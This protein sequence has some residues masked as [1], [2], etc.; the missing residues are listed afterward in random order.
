[1]KNSLD[2][3]SE[4]SEES[5][6][7]PGKREIPLAKTDLQDEATQRRSVT[8]LN[9]GRWW[10][11]LTGLI[12]VAPVT[13][14]IW[15][16]YRKWHAALGSDPSAAGFWRTAF[17]LNVGRFVVEIGLVA[18]IFFI[19]KPRPNMFGVRNDLESQRRAGEDKPDAP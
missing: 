10:I 5:L 2:R 14:T 8:W 18:L 16:N 6:F 13:S 1:L 3:H 19:L 7:V 15:G 11:C 4:R 17:Y 9:V 12:V